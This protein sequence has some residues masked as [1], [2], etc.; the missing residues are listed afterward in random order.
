[1]RAASSSPKGRLLESN[2]QPPGK[3]DVVLKVPAGFDAVVGLARVE[4]QHFE[5]STNR[6]VLQKR[7]AFEL[8]QRASVN[9]TTKLESPRTALSFHIY[10][11]I[12]GCRRGK[13]C[14]STSKRQP[15]LQCARGVEFPLDM[16]RKKQRSILGAHIR[17][18]IADL[19]V[20]RRCEK[21]HTDVESRVFAKY[22]SIIL[23]TQRDAGVQIDFTAPN[24]TD[25]RRL[26]C[27]DNQ[28]NFILTGDLTCLSKSSCRSKESDP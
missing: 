7:N 2:Q 26:R 1:M 14:V 8:D 18:G 9:A 16:G 11:A 25:T 3:D 5:S 24:P 17:R 13:V 21:V 10:I 28:S 23:R 6:Q 12:L 22:A 27:S 20:R 19:H 4:I 15:R